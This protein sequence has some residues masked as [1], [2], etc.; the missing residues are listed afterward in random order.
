MRASPEREPTWA[1]ALEGTVVGAIGL[2]VD[3]RRDTG[4]LHY[5]LGRS[6]WGHGIMPEA[7]AA[8]VDWGFQ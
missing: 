4:E 2:S 1:I 8:V 5:G 3:A 7:V 6:Y